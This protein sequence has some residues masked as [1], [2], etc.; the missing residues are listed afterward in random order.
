MTDRIEALERLAKLRTDG[1]LTDQEFVTQKAA[2]LHP[3]N[4]PGGPASPP[5][6]TF[7][8]RWA[9]GRKA[10]KGIRRF[11]RWFFG[12]QLVGIVLLGVYFLTRGQTL[13]GIRNA[14][15]NESEQSASTVQESSPASVAS[16][17][18]AEIVFT[19]RTLADRPKW[20]ALGE[21]PNPLTFC[22]NTKAR[23]ANGS[24]RTLNLGAAVRDSDISWTLGI[25]KQGGVLAFDV[26]D[27]GR[28]VLS[29]LGDGQPITTYEVAACNAKGRF[30]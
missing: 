28:F 22:A 11:I 20:D 29:D 25:V 19:D 18:E 12:I 3:D 13:E 10:T 15:A 27:E 9:E 6:Q 7:G 17:T 14:T 16:A 21:D 24:S 2:L 30:L 4:I 5:S 23:I 1:V 8:E 26:G